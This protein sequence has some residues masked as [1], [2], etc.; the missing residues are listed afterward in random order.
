MKTKSPINTM[1]RRP[2]TKRKLNIFHN[3]DFHSQ[4][5][6]GFMEMIQGDNNKHIRQSTPSQKNS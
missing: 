4:K 6:M 5:A 2:R 1:D 3:I